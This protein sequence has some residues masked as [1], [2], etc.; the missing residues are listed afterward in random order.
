V[1]D[2][3]PRPRII[4]ALTHLRDLLRQIQ[5]TNERDRIAAE[6][7]EV[8]AKYIISN[9]PKTGMHPTLNTL[10]EVAKSFQLTIGGAHELFGYDLE[11]VR[12]YDLRWNAGRTHIVESYVFDRDRSV[13]LPLALG[14]EDLFQSDAL[15]IDLVREWLSPISIRALDARLNRPRRSFCVHVGTQDSSGNALPPGSMALVEVIDPA[16]S[17]RPDPRFIYLLQFGDGYKCS[18]CVV[19]HGR[20]QMLTSRRGYVPAHTFSCP[21]E[22]RVAGRVRTFAQ[23]LP[24]PEDKTQDR[25][26]PGKALANLILPWEQ[27]TRERLLVTKHRRFQRTKQEAEQLMEELEQI[28]GSPLSGRTERRYR[29]P[30]HSEP[31]VSTLIQLSL[32]HFARYSDSLRGSG[33]PIT[34]RGRYSLGTMLDTSNAEDL[35][36]TAEFDRVQTANISRSALRPEFV[37]WLPLISFK[38]PNL[39]LRKDPVLRMARDCALQG[40][41]PPMGAGSWLL[42]EPVDHPPDPTEERERLGWTRPLYVLRRGPDMFTGHL[43]RESSDF[44]LLSCSGH[45]AIFANNELS[46]LQRVAGVLVPV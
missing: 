1:Y 30:S 7:R 35:L 2:Y 38:F 32:S 42:L 40:L 18:R 3:V 8:V 16:E 21:G 20:L 24:Q 15:L 25:F 22:V 13:E 44:V 6:Q 17:Q 37:D 14:K 23:T 11:A 33:P 31:H 36:A 4:D 39:N 41:E 45:K 26:L 34:D 43:E 10:A 19:T 29:H 9:L 27:P 28:F 46:S 5:P 12:H